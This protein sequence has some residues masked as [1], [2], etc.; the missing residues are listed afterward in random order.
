MNL[1]FYGGELADVVD[2]F[3]RSVNFLRE[4][5]LGKE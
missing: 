4:K 1:P 5:G 3:G 2:G